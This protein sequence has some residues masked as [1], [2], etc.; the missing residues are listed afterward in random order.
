V[1]AS[2]AALDTAKRMPDCNAPSCPRLVACV[3][4]VWA[5]LEQ[6]L[7]AGGCHLDAE[8]GACSAPGPSPAPCAQGPSRVNHGAA[9]SL[10]LWVLLPT[11]GGSVSANKGPIATVGQQIC[12]PTA[13]SN[14]RVRGWSTRGSRMSERASHWLHACA[15]QLQAQT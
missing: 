10:V 1:A 12:G 11:L 2:L 13:Q 5:S 4:R 14:A 8:S 7:G 15:R 9:A 3:S 6:G